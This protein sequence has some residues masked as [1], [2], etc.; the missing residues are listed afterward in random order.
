ME[1]ELEESF[2]LIWAVAISIFII[3]VFHFIRRY[4][5]KKE[6]KEEGVTPSNKSVVSL[7]GHFVVVEI[8]DEQETIM[9]GSNHHLHIKDVHPGHGEEEIHPLMFKKGDGQKVVDYLNSL[10]DDTLN[11]TVNPKTNE[12]HWNILRGIK[13]KLNLGNYFYFR[14]QSIEF[15]E[16][17]NKLKWNG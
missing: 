14:K 6:K 4:Y 5:A 11:F 17:L 7:K 12:I 3:L 9:I 16:H 15:V 2:A 8:Y 10:D 1:R 13:E